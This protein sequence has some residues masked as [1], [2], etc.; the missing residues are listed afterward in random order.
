MAR[1]A[2]RKGH[3]RARKH[4][5]RGR[6]AFIPSG[7]VGLKDRALLNAIKAQQ[8][9]PAHMA[10]TLSRAKRIAASMT[11][12]MKEGKGRKRGGRAMY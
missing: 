6:G 2:H 8:T 10:K 7:P 12:G 11:Y 5:K 9:M 3:K 4:T 1:K